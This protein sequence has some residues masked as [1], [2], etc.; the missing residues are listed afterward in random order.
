MFVLDSSGS[1][2][3]RNFELVRRFVLDVSRIF[4][5][6]PRNTQIGVIIFS[7][8]SQVIFNLNRY[9]NRQSLERAIRR[10]PY[11]A[12]ATD[13]AGGLKD[14]LK[15]FSTANGARPLS[16]AVPRV[17]VVLT[18]G[19]SDTFGG[20][21]KAALAA[22]AAG[23]QVYA[24]GIGESFNMKE[25]QTIASDPDDRFIHSVSRFGTREFQTLRRALRATTCGRK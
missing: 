12:G 2:G 13:T 22:L 6:G 14:L 19:R 7:D 17:A 3:E 11:L 15:A 25:L 18:D 23:I 20:T 9:Q 5:I 10:I 16:E 21:K 8:S 4:Q 1:V 24:I